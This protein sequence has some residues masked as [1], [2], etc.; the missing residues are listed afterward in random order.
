MYYNTRL[1]L[2]WA[3]IL[4]LV[5]G[6]H[7]Q[8]QALQDTLRSVP[9][10]AAP[11]SG[12]E[13]TERLGQSVTIDSIFLVNETGD[14]LSMAEILIPGKPIILNM[15]YFD[16]PKLCGLVTNGMLA[17]MKQTIWTPGNEYQVLTISLDPN[18]GYELAA[19]KRQN[20]LKSFDRPGAETG[21]SFLTGSDANLNELMKQTGFGFV[22]D[23]SS[24]Q[25]IHA[26]A[27]VV[28]S[29]EG[30]ITRYLYGIQFPELQ[31]RNAL[32][33]AAD[34]KVGSTIDKIVLYCFEYDPFSNSYVPQAINMMKLG[35]LVTMLGLGIFLG[36]FWLRERRAKRTSQSLT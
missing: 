27:L 4:L 12:A 25:F 33:E 14:T 7:L 34:G 13:I 6:T 17:G 19:E 36:L 31:L 1:Q 32:Y 20:Y 3:I 18:E 9:Q 24:E 21:W 23:E 28:L 5:T 30:V 35:G 16:C 15:G 11:V 22:W 10:Q 2:S 26:A 29:P 8:A